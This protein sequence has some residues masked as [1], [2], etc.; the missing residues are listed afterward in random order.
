MQLII[1]ILIN[2]AALWLAARYIDGISLTGSLWSILLVALVFGVVNAVL[3]PILK[4]L[5]LPVVIL[6]LGLFTII[7]NAAMLGITAVLMENFS[8]DGIVPALL[9][10]LVVSVVSAILNRVADRS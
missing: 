8:I 3:K 7:I 4:L 10:S 2:A 6:T 1:R 9:A 5:S